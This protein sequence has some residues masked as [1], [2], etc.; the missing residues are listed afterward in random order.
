MTTMN[1]N[2][3]K[4]QLTKTLEVIWLLAQGL[5]YIIW[6]FTLLTILLLGLLW[7]FIA[8]PWFFSKLFHVMKLG[9]GWVFEHF[10]TPFL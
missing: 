3:L 9:L 10:F 7:V 2:S 4:T 1:L 5:F 6:R 8:A